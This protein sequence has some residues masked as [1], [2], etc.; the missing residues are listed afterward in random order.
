MEKKWSISFILAYLLTLFV[1]KP[2]SVAAKELSPFQTKM[3]GNGNFGIYQRLTRRGPACWI[4]GHRAGWVNQRAF[5]RNKISVAHDISLVKNPNYDFPTRD[6]INFATD[7][8]GTVIK[9]CKVNVSEDKITTNEAGLYPVTYSYGKAKAHVTV[10]VRSDD[11]E[12]IVKADKTP[13]PGA[14]SATS[15]FKPGHW[16]KSFAPE[17]K[18]HI[19]LITHQF[20]VWLTIKRKSK[21]I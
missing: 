17:T 2:Q 6:A 12:G 13:R 8:S 21:F 3:I 4:D 1:I 5:L 18:S 19:F 20:K 11:N 9:P 15:W 10:E 7:K 14:G 16:G